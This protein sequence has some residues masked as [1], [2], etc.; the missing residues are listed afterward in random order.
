MQAC[1]LWKEAVQAAG[2]AGH[3]YRL[4]IC[5]A[6]L[7]DKALYW[8][9]TGGHGFGAII[10]GRRV[11]AGACAILGSNA[12]SAEPGGSEPGGKKRRPTPKTLA[13]RIGSKA[14]AALAG[15]LL[16]IVSSIRSTHSAH[17]CL[18]VR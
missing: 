17:L 10:K 12:A 3:E 8:A 15:D 16:A 6:H 5:A 9:A 7:L 11:K 14:F 1:A 18:Q 13:A 2:G 4:W